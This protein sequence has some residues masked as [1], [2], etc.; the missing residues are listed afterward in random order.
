M[1]VLMEYAPGV[2]VAQ[3]RKGAEEPGLFAWPCEG[4]LDGAPIS[5]RANKMRRL[6]CAGGTGSDVPEPA[7]DVMMGEEPP[8]PSPGA[9]EGESAVVVYNHHPAVDAAG[10]GGLH[11]LLGKWRIRPWAPVSAGAEWIRDMLREADSC[12]VRALLSGAREEG[13][14]GLAV[15][16]WVAA[17]APAEAAQASTAAETVDGEEQDA[18]GAVA[19]DVEEGTDHHQTQTVPAG[20]GEGYF[21]R[22]PQH[23]L[24]PAPLPPVGQASPAVRSW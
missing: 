3:K 8:A 18:E 21:W 6:E 5:C 1:V 23:C 9:P 2:G 24:V 19:M 15:V 20:C 16:P 12:T 10:A 14:A 4:D 22:W 11:G 13:G 17:P 7:S